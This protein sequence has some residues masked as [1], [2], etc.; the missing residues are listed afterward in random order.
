MT[1][2]RAIIPVLIGAALLLGISDRQFRRLAAK[3][4]TPAP[5]K[6]GKRLRRW[7][8]QTLREWAADGA[9]VAHRWETTR[10]KPARAREACS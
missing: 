5:L 3:G 6:L 7:S 1:R 4:L 8:V 2:A 10:T 9:P